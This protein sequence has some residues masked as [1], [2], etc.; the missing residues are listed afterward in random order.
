M[1]GLTRG[2]SLVNKNV[3]S[4]TAAARFLKTLT[5]IAATR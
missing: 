3:I 1:V 2:P 4:I 5:A